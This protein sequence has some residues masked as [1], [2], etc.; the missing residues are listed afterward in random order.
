MA[1]STVS[2]R[3]LLGVLGAV[4]FTAAMSA[5]GSSVGDDAEQSTSQSGPVKVGLVIPQ[6]GV[7]TPL[8]GD[9]KRAWE[10]WLERHAGKFGNYTVTTV[11]ADEGET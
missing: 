7:Y 9:M 2:R 10:L 1:E 4:G 11:T 3:N 5:C 6:A 8:G